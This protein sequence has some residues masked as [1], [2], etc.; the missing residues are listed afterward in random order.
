MIKKYENLGFTKQEQY[1]KVYGSIF[2]AQRCLP[3]LDEAERKELELFL[4]AV[5]HE[6][7]TEIEEALKSGEYFGCWLYGNRMRVSC[8][9][10]AIPQVRYRS[11]DNPR[12]RVLKDAVVEAL[13][14]LLNASLRYD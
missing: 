4:M 5:K 7:L 2:D 14:D 13:C 9:L 1:D 12:V 6:V 11:Y 8:I 10:E 3:E